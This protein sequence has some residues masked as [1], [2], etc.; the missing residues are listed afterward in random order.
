MAE[1]DKE[2]ILRMLTDGHKTFEE[3]SA[4]DGISKK[5]LTNELIKL[6]NDEV[7]QRFFWLESVPPKAMYRM[8]TMKRDRKVELP[9]T[10]K[11]LGEQ[12]E[13]SDL[14]EFNNDVK[15]L[16]EE[17][18][19]AVDKELKLFGRM[20]GRMEDRVVDI[21]VIDR[22]IIDDE[23]GFVYIWGAPGPDYNTYR[24]IDYGRTWAFTPDDFINK[25]KLT[26]ETTSWGSEI[27]FYIEDTENE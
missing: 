12:K 19:A 9:V 5:D 18:I 8:N 2:Y 23:S 24:F 21:G 10:R 16:F 4:G 17:K 7:I 11:I 26:H 13:Y 14:F 22:W 27:E 15:R 6:E 20:F 25:L 3:L 1:T